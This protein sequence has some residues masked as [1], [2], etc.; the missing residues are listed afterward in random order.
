[1]LL[2]AVVVEHRDDEVQLDVG[3][4][5]MGLRFQ[6]AAALGEI[7]GHQAAPLFAVALDGAEQRW[8]PAE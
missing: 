5:E 4:V 7:R 2:A 8:Q 3:H 1:M 6:E